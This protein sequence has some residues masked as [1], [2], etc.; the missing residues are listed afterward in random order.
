MAPD[1]ADIAGGAEF[2]GKNCGWNTTD[3]SG[4]GAESPFLTQPIYRN[5]RENGAIIPPFAMIYSR[6]LRR[7]I[8]RRRRFDPALLYAAGTEAVINMP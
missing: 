4:P 6:H 7:V 3:C 5:D 2:E 8:G 1:S